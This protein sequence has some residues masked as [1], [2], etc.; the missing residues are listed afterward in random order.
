MAN[1]SYFDAAG[2]RFLRDLAK[3]NNRE[4]FNAQKARCVSVQDFFLQF[5]GKVPFQ[6]R[7]DTFFK[8]PARIC[9]TK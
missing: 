9:G 6:K 7:V 5:R 8:R 2:F 3:N 4:W 1:G